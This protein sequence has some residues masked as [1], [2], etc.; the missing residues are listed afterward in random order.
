MLI[1]SLEVLA[2]CKRYTVKSLLCYAD[3]Y[4][5]GSSNAGMY[6][7][8]DG[9]VVG[10]P[11]RKHLYMIATSIGDLQTDEKMYFCRNILCLYGVSGPYPGV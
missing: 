7:I 1:E 6:N 3:K 5:M 4:K 2:P 10:D 8:F 9:R 11:H